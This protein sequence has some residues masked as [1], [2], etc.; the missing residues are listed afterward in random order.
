MVEAAASC[1]SPAVEIKPSGHSE[2]TQH[3]EKQL[4]AWVLVDTTQDTHTNRKI[5][6]LKDLSIFKPVENFNKNLY[7]PKLI[8]VAEKQDLKCLGE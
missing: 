4:S 5:F 7:N 6:Y 3:S 1:M 2:V 8:T